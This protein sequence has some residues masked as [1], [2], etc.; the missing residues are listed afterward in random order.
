METKYKTKRGK[1]RRLGIIFFVLYFV[2]ISSIIFSHTHSSETETDNCP[3]CYIIKNFQP[4]I[5]T[6]DITAGIFFSYFFLF[7]PQN[8]ILPELTLRDFFTRGPPELSL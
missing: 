8:L 6:A 5:I 4:V 2:F 3:I 1:L 7:L